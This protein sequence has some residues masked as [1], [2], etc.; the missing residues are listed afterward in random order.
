MAS[1]DTIKSAF[2]IPRSDST[3]AKRLFAPGDKPYLE[4]THEIIVEC[5][6]YS[7]MFDHL[8]RQEYQHSS[9]S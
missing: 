7:K 8:F 9:C 2:F 6:S 1:N 5:N 3:M 4:K